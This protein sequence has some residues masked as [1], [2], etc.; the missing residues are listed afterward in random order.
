MLQK[1]DNRM[2]NA[3]IGRLTTAI[4]TATIPNLRAVA[5]WREVAPVLDART[6]VLM[7]PAVSPTVIA[8]NN[9][10]MAP[11]PLQLPSA[12]ITPITSR[13]GSAVTVT[14]PI[15]TAGA[16][17]SRAGDGPSGETGITGV[18]GSSSDC[19]SGC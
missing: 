7:A 2:T 11:I 14:P 3:L 4:T 9:V 17:G 10:S 1:P 15:Q 6:S 12:D 16:G 5:R 8:I 19:D 18:L 13:I